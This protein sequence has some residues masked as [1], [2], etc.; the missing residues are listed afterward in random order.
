MPFNYNRT[1]GKPVLVT[2]RKN[3]TIDSYRR[4]IGE[5]ARR[6]RGRHFCDSFQKVIFA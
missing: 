1:A 4:G 3:A 5:E 6:R 2:H